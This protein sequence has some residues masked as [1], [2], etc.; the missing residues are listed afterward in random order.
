MNQSRRNFLSSGIAAAATASVQGP[1]LTHSSAAFIDVIRPPD[2]AAAYVEGA[3]RINLSASGSRWQSEDV[4]VSVDEAR[5]GNTLSISV[6][7]PRRPL[8]RLHFRWWGRLPEGTRFL[9]DHWERSYG[10]LEWRGFAAERVMPWYFLAATG[11]GTHG[12][13]VKTGASAFCFWQVD[14]DGISLWMDVRNGGS[15]VHLGERQLRA[16]EVVALRGLPDG[17]PFHAACALCSALCDGP[18]LPLSPVYGSNNWYYLYGDNMSA[19]NVMRDA[20]QLAELSPVATNPPYMVMDEGWGKAREGSGPWRED[21]LRFP[22]VPELP[23]RMKKLGVRAG[24]WV[25]P[26]ISIDPRARAWKLARDDKPQAEGFPTVLD[27]SLPEVLDYLQEGLR[28]VREWGYELIKHDYSTFD[29]LGRWGFAMGEELTPPGWHFGDRG[30]TT[31][32]IVLQFYRALRQ[33]VGDAVL[34]GCNTVGHLG[35]GIFELQRTGDDTSG[36]DWNRTRKMGVNTLAFRLPQ[37]RRFFLAD[38]DCAAFSR[39]V[40]PELSRRWLNLVA[41]SGT[42]LF[43]S[44][45][46]AIVTAEDKSV[47]KTALDFAARTQP[48]AEPL[49]WMETM[50]PCQWQLGRNKTD[51]DWFGKD[52]VD[53]FAD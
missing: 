15:G 49:D 31:A 51:F 35:A 9:G 39:S 7:S 28:R 24:I 25:R 4:E 53:F 12:Y 3:G 18:R 41:R 34:L 42:A 10:D 38:P 40:S 52:G 21:N 45:D 32:E 48:A 16:A 2:F 29:I 1:G 5:G 27:P 8:E 50:T 30:K 46:P 44:A 36:R 11:Q 20:G 17:S 19:E 6:A 13:G 43:I 26:L 23:G 14:E 47:L 22:E 33:G 37:H